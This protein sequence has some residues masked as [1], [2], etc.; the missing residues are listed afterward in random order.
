M[1]AN[2]PKNAPK[3]IINLYLNFQ[4]NAWFIEII[5]SWL[6]AVHG[7]WIWTALLFG[8]PLSIFREPYFMIMT[9][10]NYVPAVQ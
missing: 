5:F 10:V 7:I 9:L 3:T 6:P 8:V 1:H 2:M 4:K